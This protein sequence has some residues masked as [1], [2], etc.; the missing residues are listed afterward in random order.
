MQITQAILLIAF[1]LHGRS[2]AD[3]K[4]NNIYLIKQ[5]QDVEDTTSAIGDNQIILSTPIATKPAAEAAT[6]EKVV[7]AEKSPDYWKKLATERFKKDCQKFP[8][9]QKTNKAKNVILLLGDGMGMPTISAGRFYA[10][11]SLGRNGSIQK[12]PF[13]EWPYNTMARTCDLETS[14]T[15]S[16]SSATAYLTGTKTRTG[17]IGLTGDINVKQCGKWSETYHT[18][19]VLEA[20][21]KA[22]KATGIVTTTRITHASPS[23]CYGHVSYRDMESDA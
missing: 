8:S 20:A 1:L 3:D 13:E 5:V 11:Q 21:Y 14:V 9:L 6:P 18:E 15:D 7:E 17:M 22:G 19:S 16:A 10:A 4:D 2:L 23:G 12:H